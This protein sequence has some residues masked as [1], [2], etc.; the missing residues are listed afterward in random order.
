MS[1]SHQLGFFDVTKRYEALSQ[2]GDP[3][4]QLTQVVP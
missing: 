3:L 2:Q 1:Q 4:E